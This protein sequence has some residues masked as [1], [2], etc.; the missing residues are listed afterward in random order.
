MSKTPTP[1][2]AANVTITN[3]TFGAMGGLTFDFVKAKNTN[4]RNPN[5]NNNMNGI[6]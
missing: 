2:L 1:L 6:P 4:N 5:T 3:N